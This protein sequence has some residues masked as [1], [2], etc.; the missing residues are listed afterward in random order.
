MGEIRNTWMSQIHSGRGLLISIALGVIALALAGRLLMK[1]GGAR[2]PWVSPASGSHA[3]AIE[4]LQDVLEAEA[5]ARRELADRITEL[6]AQL[7]LLRLA[8]DLTKENPLARTEP[9]RKDSPSAEDESAE[10][11]PTLAIEFEA[12]RFD[13]DVLLGKGIH[14]RDVTRLHD[15][16][17]RYEL[18]RQEIANSA[19]REG[20][21]FSDRHRNELARSDRE[22]RDDLTDLEYDRY[23]YALGQPNRLVAAEVLQGS[24]ASDAGLQR[25]D[26]ILRYDDVR[27]FNPGEI[28]KASAL[29]DPGTSVPV[30]VLRDGETRT[31]YMQT[32]TLGVVLEHSSNEP[33]TD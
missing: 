32:G 4:Q 26:V 1:D 5:Q 2:L 19:L 11:Q 15:R 27:V 3:A 33:L 10:T 22:L 29:A 16:W 20:W 28:L 12:T 8:S 21:F 31:V 9:E 23:L 6:E 14:S 24:A 13:D 18:E 7:S 17:A 25:G 30:V